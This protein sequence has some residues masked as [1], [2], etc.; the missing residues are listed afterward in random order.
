L[1]QYNRDI[2]FTKKVDTVLSN[3]E[4][5]KRYV[6]E[7][8][9]IGA[10][11]RS[12]DEDER[13]LGVL[14]MIY[15]GNP[16]NYYHAQIYS[17]AKEIL[18]AAQTSKNAEVVQ[19]AKELH[20]QVFGDKKKN[21]KPIPI[22]AVQGQIE[23]LARTIA[24]E[25]KD[26]VVIDTLPLKFKN[27]LDNY[28][29]F[30][31]LEQ[32]RYISA[33][34]G[35]AEQQEKVKRKLEEMYRQLDD[36]IMA[37]R[38]YHRE[39][40]YDLE[41][42]EKSKIKEKAPLTEKLTP[43]EIARRIYKN[44]SEVGG[45]IKGMYNAANAYDSSALGGKTALGLA[46]SSYLD[47]KAQIQAK[48]DMAIEE[49]MNDFV[50]ATVMG[51][52][53]GMP[54]FAVLK[55]PLPENIQGI[56]DSIAK[57]IPSN[58][59]DKEAYLKQFF[60]ENPDALKELTDFSV[61]YMNLLLKRDP[62]KLEQFKRMALANLK[63]IDND[64]RIYHKQLFSTINAKLR[65]GGITVTKVEISIGKSI[66]FLEK[67]T[68]AHD[69]TE[70]L[71]LFYSGIV[72]PMLKLGSKEFIKIV[73][74]LQQKTGFL[75]MFKNNKYVMTAA[76]WLSNSTKW[77]K[78]INAKYSKLIGGAASTLSV[79]M[80]AEQPSDI[81]Q[82]ILG[83]PLQNMVHKMLN[84]VMHTMYRLFIAFLKIVGKIVM[85]ALAAIWPVLLMAA[86]I[87]LPVIL[88]VAIFMSP[89]NN[90]PK[91]QDLAYILDNQPAFQSMQNVLFGNEY[92]INNITSALVSAEQNPDE[93][94]REKQLAEVR[95]TFTKTQEFLVANAMHKISAYPINELLATDDIAERSG[96][97][98]AV[99]VDDNTYTVY[100]VE[101]TTYACKNA[102]TVTTASTATIPLEPEPQ[103]SSISYTTELPVLTPTLTC[104]FEG[105]VFTST[106]L[107]QTY[108]DARLV[109][110]LLN[111]REDQLY[112]DGKHENRVLLAYSQTASTYY[113][114]VSKPRDAYMIDH[115]SLLYMPMQTS[116][117]KTV[118]LTKEDIEDLI[119]S[120]ITK[121][122]PVEVLSYGGQLKVQYVPP[123]TVPLLIPV[124][125]PTV[126]E[127]QTYYTKYAV[128]NPWTR[129]AR[130]F[131][132]N[133]E[134]FIC[135]KNGT[136]IYNTSD[137]SMIMIGSGAIDDYFLCVSKK[138]TKLTINPKD[139]GGVDWTYQ[140]PT[141]VSTSTTATS[142]VHLGAGLEREYVTIDILD[143]KKNTVVTFSILAAS[144]DVAALKAQTHTSVANIPI[145]SP[146]NT[147]TFFEIYY[148]DKNTTWAHIMAHDVPVFV[149]EY[150]N[151][152]TNGDAMVYLYWK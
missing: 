36:R 93:K 151:E 60:K 86:L 15:R 47:K 43:A 103:N 34:G 115:T 118:T 100:K 17:H 78:Y 29:Y 79:L 10:F 76:T 70:Q 83:K 105:Q 40:A 7:L 5:E 90:I 67:F 143:G 16:S 147:N 37:N 96:D 94:S 139:F 91:D 92:G 1:Q 22:E 35:T 19:R 42:I 140:L 128:N 62:E 65:F 111:P 31:E 122:I 56:L 80:R 135:D 46:I 81:I 9:T 121:W 59:Q 12:K 63:D 114:T 55:D 4:H 106:A 21:I 85:K 45:T 64:A 71:A 13:K 57:E 98:Y 28:N 6:A 130:T 20:D 61:K 77:A 75:N 141:S 82:A 101:T 2:S 102:T 109:K 134:L 44:A 133:A 38:L 52:A 25:Y 27:S 14:Y 84:K 136:I 123:H 41:H 18:I 107:K 120:E 87:L 88:L 119:R 95:Q 125:K 49:T 104:E 142:S 32:Y 33:N 126:Q 132:D 50:G 66:A 129:I 144:V 3:N 116:T 108:P 138:V 30:K 113:A 112:V 8:S 149:N 48:I 99:L 26:D 127:M 72:V 11:L 51:L 145:V 97:K 23:E 54:V 137:I 110:V 152:T 146:S 124:K 150:T 131:T 117:Q 58:T 68:N 148:S 73:N 74:K 39:I 89:G 53:L 69:F 24:E